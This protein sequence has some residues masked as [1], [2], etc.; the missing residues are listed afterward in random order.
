MKSMTASQERQKAIDDELGRPGLYLAVHEKRTTSEALKTAM[1]R[2]TMIFKPE[3]Y[4]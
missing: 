2:A 1:V 4:G 3:K